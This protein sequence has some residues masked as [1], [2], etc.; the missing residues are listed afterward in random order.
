MYTPEIFCMKGTFV[1]ITNM[2]IK[3]LCNHKVWDF[4]TAFH[5]RKLFMTFEK[6][7]LGRKESTAEDTVY[8][9]IAWQYVVYLSL[10][11]IIWIIR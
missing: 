3:Q 8:T 9:Q 5:V 2:W 4:A 10:V 6:R 1:D 7:V 11:L